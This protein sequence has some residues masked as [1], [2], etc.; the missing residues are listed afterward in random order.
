M[1]L[2]RSITVETLRLL[3]TSESRGDEEIAAESRGT[4]ENMLLAKIDGE[5]AYSILGEAKGSITIKP[6]KAS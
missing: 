2:S 1:P 3:A 6:L 5:Q 4:I